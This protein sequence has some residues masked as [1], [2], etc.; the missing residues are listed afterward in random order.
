MFKNN[1]K[2]QP[3][4]NDNRHSSNGEKKLPGRFQYHLILL[5][6]SIQK[7]FIQQFTSFRQN[8]SRMLNA[9]YVV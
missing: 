8:L 5:K 9:E 3:S 7:Y 1:C 6:T 2:G 4:V